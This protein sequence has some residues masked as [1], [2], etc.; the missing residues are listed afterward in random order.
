MNKNFVLLWQ[1]QFV[2]QLGS[3]AFT[4]AMMFWLKHATGSAT[5]MG[6]IMMISMLPMVIMSPLGGTFADRYSRRKIIILC[7]LVHGA[8][9]LSLAVLMFAAPGATGLIVAWLTI[10]AV[11]S[12]VI[13]AFF[14]PAVKA[15]VPSIVPAGKVAA[16]NSFNEGSFQISTLVGQGAGGVLYRVLGAPVLFLIDGLTFLYSAVSEMFM[17][18]PQT[19]PEKARNWR[20]EFARFDAETRE[21]LRYAWGRVGMRNLFVAAAVLNFFSMPFFIL[22]PF[23]VEDVLGA[24]PDWYGFLLAGYGGGSLLGY[25]FISSVGMSGR[26]RGKLLVVFLVVVS[27]LL[28]ALGFVDRPAV[29]LALMIAAGF[30][31][32]VFN[33]TTLTLIQQSTPEDKRGRMFGL[34]NTLVMGLAPVSM[35]LTGVVADLIGQN[36][37]VMFIICG[38]VLVTVSLVVSANRE[39]REFL[40]LEISRTG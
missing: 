10:V 24:S 25:T 7:D 1:G 37:S 8:S 13:S 30:I 27:V 9:V 18:I 36:V 31:S 21:G 20:E 29:S 5:V 34:L 32:G 35:G 16:A 17:D 22:F 26:A 19:V 14:M 11:L 39:F 15:A 38:A 28:G 6:S 4:I 3:Q 33:I 40:S 12:G 23:Y 2:S